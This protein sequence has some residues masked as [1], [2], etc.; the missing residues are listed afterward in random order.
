LCYTKKESLAK[1]ASLCHRLQVF[2]MI[3]LSKS[4]NDLLHAV[5]L[6]KAS[7]LVAFP[8]ETF[9]GLG[10]AAL[11]EAA[12]SAVFQ[13]KKRD[14]S[15]PVALIVADQA[16]AF[17]LW[18]NIP[19]IVRA[20]AKKYWPGPLTIVLPGHH[21]LPA[22]LRSPYGLGAR[23]SSHPTARELSRLLQ[24]P[25][26]ATSANVSGQPAVLRASEIDEK[27]PGADAIIEDDQGVLGG[28]PSTIV[29]FEGEQPIILRQGPIKL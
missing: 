19:D 10:A 18:P 23:V 26:V 13:L 25:L 15:Q 2:N 28:A 21:H 12:L 17:S 5:A 9:Y 7:R 3:R 27:L 29:A 1:R 16:Q 22:A 11:D 20:L 6:L 14:P 24:A 4:P 8:T